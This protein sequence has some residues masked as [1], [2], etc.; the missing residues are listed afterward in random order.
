M[1]DKYIELYKSAVKAEKT[2]LF[3]KMNIERGLKEKGCFKPIIDAIELSLL[4]GLLKAYIDCLE[5]VID[6][7][8]KGAG[9]ESS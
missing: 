9:N 6:T 1:R 4:L 2:I 7:I 3:D 5:K 8:E